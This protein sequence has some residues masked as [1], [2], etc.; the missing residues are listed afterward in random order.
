MGSLSLL[1]VYFGR[2]SWS[3]LSLV[4]AAG[5][6]LIINPSWIDNLSFQL[7]FLATLGIIIFGQTKYSKSQSFF[8]EVM[9][10]LKISLRITLAA[11]AFTLPLIFFTFRQVS[12]ISPVTNVLIGWT[13]VPIMVL[14][15]VLSISGWIYLPLAR[16]AGWL[17]WVPLTYLVEVVKLTALIPF[18][19][20]KL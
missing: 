11:Q 13:I 4:L 2:Q 10:E 7:S 14:G 1:A 20:I 17:V 3:L 5:I 16:I 15:F 19:A 18:A 12:L 9:R 6:M 8:D